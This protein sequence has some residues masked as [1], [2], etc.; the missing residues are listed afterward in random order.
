MLIASNNHKHADQMLQSGCVSFF[1]EVLLHSTLKQVFLILFKIFFVHKLASSCK[2][3][4]TLCYDYSFNWRYFFLPTLGWPIHL[5]SQNM[6][7][8]SKNAKPRPFRLRCLSTQ[9]MSVRLSVCPAVHLATPHIYAG[10]LNMKKF[11][12]AL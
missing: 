7:K 9:K 8:K 12:L 5:R 2:I 10:P 1:Y 3:T 11:L 4:V 6:Q